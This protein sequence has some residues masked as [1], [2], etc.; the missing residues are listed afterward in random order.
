MPET[1]LEYDQIIWTV[2]SI[3]VIS[4]VIILYYINQE[5]ISGQ[6]SQIM[7]LVLGSSILVYSFILILGYGSKKRTL[8]ETNND[9]S[10]FD[11]E[12]S[13]RLRNRSYPHARW[14]AEIILFVIWVYYLLISFK[15]WNTSGVLLILVI[16]LFFAFLSSVA[17]NIR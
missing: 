17:N 3:G 10:H 15:V 16:T 7:A 8:I 2:F 4:S 14:L 13:R 1:P 5:M 12:F 11:G 9:L 6:N